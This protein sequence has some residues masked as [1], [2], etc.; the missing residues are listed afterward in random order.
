M[1]NEKRMKVLNFLEE[2]S[3]FL[4]SRKNLDLKE[5]IN[6][7]KD[8][9]DNENKI[10]FASGY[11]SSN[12]NIH[13]LTGALPRLFIDKKLFPDNETI[14][15]FAKEVLNIDVSSRA[16]RSRHE[17][18]GRIVCETES[19]SDNKLSTLVKSL[20]KITSNEFKM[21]K[22]REVRKDI[23]F[24]WNETIQMLSK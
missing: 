17:I 3:W 5:V 14:I 15:R 20:H 21:K 23:N 2:L 22:M 19:L 8:S 16:K 10:K 7:L 9:L 12:P 11:Q 24:S 1:I 4:D 13:F 6:E 18:I